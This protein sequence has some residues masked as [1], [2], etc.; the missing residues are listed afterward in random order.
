[1]IAQAIRG[2]KGQFDVNSSSIATCRTAIDRMSRETCYRC[3]WPKALCWC[4]SIR[5][6]AT[7]TRVVLL[8]NPQNPSGAVYDATELQCLAD[9]M[10]AAQKAMS[11]PKVKSVMEKAQ[12]NPKVM[13]AVQ[14][15]WAIPWR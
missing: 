3:F 13:A 2:F 15:A 11:N 5:P 6:M 7:R 1:M 10:A 8:N 4:D 9:A 12:R 14:S